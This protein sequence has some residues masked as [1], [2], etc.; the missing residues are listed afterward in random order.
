MPKKTSRKPKPAPRAKTHPLVRLRDAVLEMSA[1]IE[2]ACA[3]D[4]KWTS[5]NGNGANAF[6]AAQ[7]IRPLKKIADE[8]T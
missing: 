6:E 4:R 5:W 7:V 8:C 2:Q 3:A 1:E